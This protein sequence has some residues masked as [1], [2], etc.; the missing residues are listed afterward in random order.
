[1]E[2]ASDTQGVERAGAGG[3]ELVDELCSFAGR[4]AGTDAERRAANAFAARLLA[5]GRRADV[6][7]AYVHPQWALVHAL[8]AAVGIAG[9]IVAVSQPGIGF[10]LVLFAATSAYLDLNTRF[11]FLRRL[12]FRRASQNVVS[13]GGNPG[14][15]MRLVLVAHLDAGRSGFI[16]GK[17][18]ISL[19]RRLS[20]RMRV[21]LSP[22]RVYF[23]GGPAALLP[24]IGLR[25]AGVDA[26]WVAV[27]QMI[28]TVT[29]IAAIFVLL[30]IALSDTVPGAI[31]DASGV[32]AVLG[33]AERLRAEPPASLDVWVVLTG[34]GEPQAEG[35]RSF[36]AAHRGT[37]DPQ[38]TAVVS[39]DSVG[40]GSPAYAV[41]EGAVVSTPTDPT[42]V[43]ICEALA[44]SG[45][46][47]RPFR[48]P[49]TGDA[50][51]AR[52]RGIPAITIAGLDDEGLPSPLRHTDDDV[53]ARCDA[54][55]IGRA[56]DLLVSLARLMDRDAARRAPS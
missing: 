50:A 16:Y 30:D 49:H 42:L 19:A 1:V 38:S 48:S 6:E 17:R 51:A 35:M 43:S 34:A 21:L 46:A 23:W 45:I 18:S 27:V 33:A 8:H 37:L 24:V 2:Q 52:L 4:G 40:Y 12:F 13:P 14:A 31:D 53:P 32:A 28:P 3:N 26:G 22:W 56:A 41:S 10:A 11:Y 25:M 36:V 39:A 55:A 47:A 9:S 20:P 54:Q 15:P 7:P 5:L 44:S 29:L